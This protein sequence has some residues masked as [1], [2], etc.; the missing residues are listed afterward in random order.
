MLVIAVCCRS[1]EIIRKG[2]SD[3]TITLA[4]RESADLVEVSMSAGKII[5]KM[6]IKKTIKEKII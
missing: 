1:S 6:D 4:Q 2:R 3:G 5:Q